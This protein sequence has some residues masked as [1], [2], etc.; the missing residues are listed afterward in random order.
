MS[1]A[2]TPPLR[3]LLVSPFGVLGGQERW[4]LG[5]VESTATRLDPDAVVL[6][7]GPLRPALQ[8]QGVSTVALPTGADLVSMVRTTSALYRRLR[9]SDVD[10]V[11]ANGVKAAAVVVPAA[12]L[13]GV[14][15]VW[16]KHDFSFDRSLGRLLGRA[17]SRV[18]ATSAAVAEAAGRDDA[19]LVPPP[20]PPLDGPARDVAAKF[21]AE[22]GVDFCSGPVVAVVGRLVPYK[23]TDTVVRSLAE[24][25][26]ARWR[27]VVVGGDDPS[28]PDERQRITLL[29]QRLGVADRVHVVGEV[30]AAGRHL[31]AF[32]AVAVLTRQ[33]DSGFGRE[34]YSLVGLEALAAGVPL[35]G[36]TGNPEVVRMASEAGEVVAPDDPAAVAAALGRLEVAG[37]REELASRALG[38]LRAHPGAADCAERVSQV[39]AEA[40]RRPGAGLSGPPVTVLTCLKNESGYVD[41]VVS[42]VLAQLRESDEYLLVDDGSDDGTRA[43]IDRWAQRDPR[44]RVLD[45]PALNLSAARNFAMGV[46]RHDVVACTDAGC[47]PVPGW[48]DALRAPFAEPRPP[49][50]VIGVYSVTGGSALQD[51]LAI[52][53]FPQVAEARRPTPWVR[54]FWAAFGRGFSARRLDGR[55]MAVSVAAWR[56]VDGFDET[57]FSSEDAAFGHA[58]LEAGFRAVLALDA[59]VAWAQGPPAESVAMYR[60]YGRASADA[61]DWRLVTRDLVRASAYG[62]VPLLARRGGPAVR[63][64]LALGAAAYLSVPCAR[65][66][67][68]RAG[69]RVLVAV[70]AV[71][72]AKDLAKVAGCLEG[73][74]RRAVRARRR[75]S[76]AS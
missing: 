48:L 18:I 41:G 74:W 40:A 34:G 66:V 69:S 49:D 76:P 31:A 61:G 55:S 25:G 71:L 52:A 28:A 70:P 13:A 56:A 64:G 67:S 26:A 7:D 53:G 36:A 9:R 35:V 43:E 46:V 54:A 20:R 30:A 8:A 73:L 10:V 29:A 12:T 59:E 47:A 17:S 60:G 75:G 45:G 42:R 33:D 3:C 16:A 2:T 57:M 51:A 4:L 32:D 50:L 19:D 11:L 72:V 38:L 1:P 65:V 6:A 62:V 39:L 68:Q 37:R 63:A 58:V 23:G 14:P 15:V 27:L 44:I 21:W 24:R 5:L 22:H